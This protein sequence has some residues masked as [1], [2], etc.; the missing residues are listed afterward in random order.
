MLGQSKITGAVALSIFAGSRIIGNI[1]GG[2]LADRIGQKKVTVLGF[3]SLS[4]LLPLLIVV[5]NVLIATIVLIPTGFMLFATCSPMIVLGQNYLPTRVG[6]SSG[7]TL[8]L[9][10]AIG[11]GTAPFIGKLADIYG[12]W[13]ALASVAFLPIAILL[14]ALTLPA[15]SV[16]KVNVDAINEEAR[17]GR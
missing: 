10:V 16:K 9:A 8:E 1:A 15:P 5:D 6:L 13:T 7:V 11:G 3:L 17:T 4:V 12:A 2:T 14:I